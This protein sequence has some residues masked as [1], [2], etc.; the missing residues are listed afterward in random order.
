MNILV[1]GANSTIAEELLKFYASEN[2]NLFLVSRNEKKLIALQSDLKVRGAKNVIYKVFDFTDYNNTEKFIFDLW[3]DFKVFDLAILAYGQLGVQEQDQHDVQKTKNI[4]EINYLSK[5]LLLT[6]LSNKFK[7]QTS[8]TI[9][10]MTSVAGVRGRK[11]NY[12][13]G[14]AKAGLSAFLS[15]LAQRLSSDS[16]KI[17]DLKIGPT[18][19]RMTQHLKSSFVWSDSK[20]VALLIKK[21]IQTKSGIVYLPSYWFVIMLFIRLIPSKIYN[22]LN[23]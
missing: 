6:T 8:G 16:V 9:A 22:R 11:S 21:S 15:G 17:I 7:A 23:L 5:V 20:K 13:Y 10:V 4:I 2:H 19:T 3:H 18:K 14:S 12:I 1:L